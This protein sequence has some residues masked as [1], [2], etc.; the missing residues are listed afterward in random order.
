MKL[1]QKKDITALV[2]SILVLIIYFCTLL[3]SSALAVD[4]VAPFVIFI[5]AALLVFTQH[6]IN[7]PFISFFLCCYIFTMIAEIMG[8]N[9]SLFFG[10]YDFGKGLGFTVKMVP[11]VMG[12]LGFIVVYCSGIFTESLYRFVE[13]K[14]PPDN[15][16]P[17]K[18][19]KFSIVVDGAFI[20]TFFVWAIERAAA[21]LDWW[22]WPGAN[23]PLMNYVT[24]FI[25]SAVLLLVFELLKFSKTNQFAVHLF[26]VMLLFFFAVKTLL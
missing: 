25:L 13:K 22:H 4:W 3:S 19:Q 21:K 26:I 2:L 11:L 5:L 18:V 16:L 1:E 15:L 17:S 9:K 8:V 20:S 6:E 14:Y 23:V 10:N 12:L 7:P 24:W